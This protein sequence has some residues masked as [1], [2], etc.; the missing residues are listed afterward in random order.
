MKSNSEVTDGFSLIELLVVIAVIAILIALLLPVLSRAKAKAQQ[1]VC[2]TNLRQISLGVR[3]Y[4]DDSN[5]KTPKPGVAV[6]NPYNAYKELMKSYVGL[7][8]K[9][10]KQDRLFA[11]PADTF[12][13][14]YWLGH[15]PHYAPLEGY[16]SGS[17]CARPDYDFSSYGFNAGNLAG[18]NDHPANRPGIAGLPLTSIKRPARTVLAAEVP[19]FVPFSWHKPKRPLK[20]PSNLI[21]NNAMN[22]V[23]FVDCHVAY[24]KV[25]WKTSWPLT[26]NYDPPGG[27]AGY[28][29]PPD[30]YDYQ[31]SPN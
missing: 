15:Y 14:D 13:C 22:M 9:S 30:D 25:F 29:D 7:E 23:S 27:Y 2:I 17:I 28:Y 3:L 11:C 26:A 4:S 5:D 6:L 31:W 21:F 1:T 24:V 19:A 20:T 8:G 10:S 18:D 12:Y 16:V